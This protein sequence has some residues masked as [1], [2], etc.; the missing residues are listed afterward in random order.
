[1]DPQVELALKLQ[2][3]DYRTL[4]LNELLSAGVA[5]TPSIV[6]ASTLLTCTP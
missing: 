1:M 4:Y 2:A 3:A 5:E 6:L